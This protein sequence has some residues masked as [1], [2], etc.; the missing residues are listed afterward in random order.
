MAPAGIDG[1]DGTH[2]PTRRSSGPPDRRRH[3]PF[4]LIPALCFFPCPLHLL[5]LRCR[6][7]YG[8]GSTLANRFIFGAQFRPWELLLAF[9]DQQGD[10]LRCAQPGW[11]R[12]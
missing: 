3:H 4:A 5:L 1:S 2:S 12:Q 9:D 8:Q 7:F 11:P 10:G 6:A